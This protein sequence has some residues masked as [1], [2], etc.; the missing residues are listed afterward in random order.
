MEHYSVPTGR[1]SILVPL[2]TNSKMSQMLITNWL[3]LVRRKV[4]FVMPSMHLDPTARSCL[5]MLLQTFPIVKLLGNNENDQTSQYFCQ[6]LSNQKTALRLCLATKVPLNLSQYYFLRAC[7]EWTMLYSW[8]IK[9]RIVFFDISDFIFCINWA[10]TFV[11]N[12]QDITSA[13]DQFYPFVGV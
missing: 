8:L 9:I 11:V 6:R 2:L 7:F 3:I 13:F 1:H 10:T 4:T 5:M 12:F